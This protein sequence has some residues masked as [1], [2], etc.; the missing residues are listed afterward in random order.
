MEHAVSV[1]L[2]KA[3]EPGLARQHSHRWLVLAVLGLAQLMVV[4][5]A[6]I[7][8]IALPS[9]QR[10]LG[11]SNAD[12]AWVVTGY[13]LAFGSLLLLGGRISD[14][15][16]G[17]K[18]A[19]IIGLVG[20][21]AASALG[22]FSTTFTMLLAAR[23]AQGA[24]GALLAPAALSLVSTTF[25]VPKERNK[26]FGI[27]GAIAGAGGGIGLILGGVLTSYLSWR[28]TL[29]VNVGIATL[30]V[31]GTLL[32]LVHRPASNHDRLDWPGVLTVTSGLFG[33]VYGLSHAETTSWTNV[34]TLTF[35]AF[36]ASLLVAFVLIERRA[37][38][39]L[40]PLRV[41]LDRNRGGSM[42][43]IFLAS[44]GMFGVFLFLTYYMQNALGYSPVR[45][46]LAFLPMIGMLI[47]M[48]QIATNLVLP[49]V[50]PRPLVPLGGV[51]AALG[52]IMLTRIGL[53]SSYSTVTLPALLVLGTG[54][55]LILSPAINT[56]TLGVASRDAGVG[57]AVVNTAQQV[58][59]SV[60]TALLNTLVASAVTAFAVGYV[61]HDAQST[62][63]ALAT[64]HG[65]ITAFRY[66]ALFLGIAAVVAGVLLRSGPA[67][68]LAQ[69]NGD[70]DP[71]LTVALP[72][73]NTVRGA[74]GQRSEPT[75]DCQPE[76]VTRP[77]MSIS[78]Q[79]RFAR[80]ST[81]RR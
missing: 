75:G 35:I 66:S 36:G 71:E 28:Y 33:V 68:S 43:A 6:T 51:F 8:N 16:L 78:E 49:R 25:V 45:T 44:G 74:H 47:V 56:A 20:F 13:A 18:R 67:A 29:F 22:G 72:S 42:L 17:Q 21:A 23:V 31:P 40:L 53:D 60:S 37:A 5:D 9:A 38:H 69:A 77:P 26:A 65:Y 27:Y 24:C 19:L 3:D 30:A 64:V 14:N 58:G 4:L 11:F 10:A 81:A 63:M 12:R 59:G 2:A 34:V 70:L 62:V 73:V 50:G 54:F 80:E 48:A 15:F 52:M 57:S 76:T 1:E 79:R 7:V 41:I 55:G 32:L 39:P 46:G 61:G